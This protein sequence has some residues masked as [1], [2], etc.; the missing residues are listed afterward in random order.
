[1]GSRVALTPFSL[2]VTVPA[3]AGVRAPWGDGAP[4][5]VF[6]PSFGGASRAAWS[7]RIG[8]PRPPDRAPSPRRSPSPYSFAGLAASVPRIRTSDTAEPVPLLRRRQHGGSG[9]CQLEEG[10]QDG[11]Q[12]HA[13]AATGTASATTASV[14]GIV[15]KVRLVNARQL[16]AIRTDEERVSRLSPAVAGDSGSFGGLKR[17]AAAGPSRISAAIRPSRGAQASRAGCSDA[18]AARRASCG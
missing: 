10:V 14:T 12:P 9:R 2:S 4:R 18:S 5:F 8:F 17:F 13:G 7:A 1:M 16:A 11:R 6:I 3:K 15:T